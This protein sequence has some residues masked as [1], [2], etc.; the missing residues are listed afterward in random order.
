MNVYET[1]FCGT[2]LWRWMT[3]RQLLPW[4]M[5]G[6]EL[7]EHVLEVGA[8]LG[9]ATEELARLAGRVTSLEY[10]HAF[11][12]KLYARMNGSNSAAIQADAAALPFADK[13]FSS[14]IAI[15]M[16]HHLGSNELQDRAF[17][18]ILR[19]LRP[20]GVFL[21]FE[22]Q[23]GW[24]HRVGHIKS[25]FVPLIPASAF[26]RLTAAGFSKVTVD[27]RSGGFRIR[28]LRARESP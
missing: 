12:V 11:A 13:T 9:A 28:A 22:I 4:M 2:R 27:F 21:A 8:G 10:D 24:L 16:L 6:S 3:R 15:L 7:G 25:T 1:W 19:V 14:A 26:A 20:G 23:D 5:Q 18:E 17:A